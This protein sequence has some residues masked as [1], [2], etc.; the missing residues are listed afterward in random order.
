MHCTLTVRSAGFL[1]ISSWTCSSTLTIY[2]V[3]TSVGYK[4]SLFRF[5]AEN[6]EV[7]CQLVWLVILIAS[8]KAAECLL[9]L[10]ITIYISKA[11]NFYSKL[12]DLIQLVDVI[13]D[14]LINKF[15]ENWCLRFIFFKFS[16][17]FYGKS[18]VFAAVCVCVC[19][20]GVSCTFDRISRV[21]P[22]TGTVLKHPS[23]LNLKRN[24]FLRFQ[25]LW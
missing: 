22:R 2:Q 19:V 17:Y 14:F 18:Y 21:I 1:L 16:L 11:Y 20:C 23:F 8:T 9:D 6:P 15:I 7:W 24:I 12:N 4:I 13:A 10:N 3:D 25:D 5:H